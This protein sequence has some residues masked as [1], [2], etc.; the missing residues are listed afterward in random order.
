MQQR[1]AAAALPRTLSRGAVSWTAA[2]APLV[3]L[4]LLGLMSPA[5][6]DGDI[7]SGSVMAG[8]SVGMVTKEQPTQEII[9]ELVEEAAA[10]LARRG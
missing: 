4:V 2:A 1:Q 3:G 7:E 6:I 9:A 10:A 8:Q 5:V